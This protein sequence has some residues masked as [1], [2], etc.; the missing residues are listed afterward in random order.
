[1]FW[2][3]VGAEESFPDRVGS[4][5]WY[6]DPGGSLRGHARC[7]R[8]PAQGRAQSGAGGETE[9]P[10]RDREQPARGV[11]GLARVCQVVGLRAGFRGRRVPSTARTARRGQRLQC[12]RAGSECSC[13][14]E[15]PGRACTED[16]RGGRGGQA[17]ISAA[18]R[19]TGPLSWGLA[20]GSPTYSPP[21]PAQPRIRQRTWS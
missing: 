1:M 13:P 15:A 4:L 20:L 19:A 11:C 12:G 17:K 14:Q 16:L 8:G 9:G 21:A 3:W 18:Q 5:W 2:L 6:L 7:P 10:G